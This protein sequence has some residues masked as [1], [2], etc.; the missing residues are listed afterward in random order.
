MTPLLRVYLSSII[1]EMGFPGGSE[2]KIC[3]PAGESDSIP[4][5]RKSLGEGNGPPLQY[6]YPGN[7]MDRGAWWAQSMGLQKS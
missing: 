1:G 6:S 3:L 5:S 4:R 2:V 7:P